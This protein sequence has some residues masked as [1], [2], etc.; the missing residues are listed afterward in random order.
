VEQAG[1]EQA[2]GADRD[3]GLRRLVAGAGQVRVRVQERG[4]PAE[5]VGPQ[6][7]QAAAASAAITRSRTPDSTIMA[8]AVTAST[9][10]A[11]SAGSTATRASTGAAQASAIS[12]ER[13]P[14]VPA[15]R[16]SPLRGS[17]I[18]YATIRTSATLANSDGSIW[19]PPGTE[20]QACAPLTCAP[21]GDSTASRPSSVTP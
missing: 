17:L 20:I 13:T 16:A 12:T 19:N 4:E 21:S 18:T 14:G 10:A 2:A 9:T 8:P 1:A 3:L 11:P 15:G 6:Q 7:V 5:L